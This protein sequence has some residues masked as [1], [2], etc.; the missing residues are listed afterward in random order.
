V[1]D[2][3]RK[4]EAFLPVLRAATW[5]A[6]DTEAD[7]LH[8]YPEKVCLIQ[9]STVSGEELV[10]PLARVNL[11]PLLDT[12]SG[13]ELI[14][15][16]ADYDLR[17]LRKHHEFVPSAIFDTMLAARLLGLRQFGLSNLVEKYLTVKL[18]KG[19]QKANWAMRPLT[20]RMERYARNDT[21]YLKPL[22]DQLKTELQASRRLAWQQESCARLIQDSTRQHLPDL[23]A[24]WRI[25]GSHLLGPPGL[26]ILRELWQWRE[27]EAVAANKPPFFVISHDALVNI[28]AAATLAQPIEPFLPRHI[29]ERRRGGLMNAL[30]QGL[31]LAPDGHPRIHRCVT[32]RPSEG[33]KRRF[34]DLQKRRDAHAAALG[35]DPTLV[36]SRGMLSDLAHDWDQHS[37]ELMTWQRELLNVQGGRASTRAQT[38]PAIGENQGSRGRSPSQT[39]PSATAPP[40]TQSPSDTPSRG[41]SE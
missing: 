32:R 38:A 31:D 22:A 6:V 41:S 26:A 33:E 37:P 36:A 17:L 3:E 25:K 9:I 40:Q 27:K 35:I 8:A 19:P 1:I 23:D 13:H 34:T 20:E 4:L 10:D 21:R 16:G 18:E 2:T 29:S 12:L 15:H 39:N 11:D 14:M 30:A 5:A 7:S 28:A 24:I